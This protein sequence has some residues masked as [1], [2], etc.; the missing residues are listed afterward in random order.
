MENVEPDRV[1]PLMFVAGECAR[2]HRLLDKSRDRDGRD[3]R[4][5]TEG[6]EELSETVN[7]QKVELLPAV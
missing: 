7:Q 1:H 4:V 3:R 2:E 6:A 5:K